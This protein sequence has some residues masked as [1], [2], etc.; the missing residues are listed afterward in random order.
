MCVSHSRGLMMRLVEFLSVRYDL[1]NYGGWS[2]EEGREEFGLVAKY[3]PKETLTWWERIFGVNK[4]LWDR[5][6]VG[7]LYIHDTKRNADLQHWVIEIFGKDKEL[8]VLKLADM[9][10]KEFNVHIECV[11]IYPVARS[12]FDTRQHGTTIGY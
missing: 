4:S 5:T 7:M 10:S 9:L 1:C 8:E 11:T 6:F 2:Y 3:E 12:V